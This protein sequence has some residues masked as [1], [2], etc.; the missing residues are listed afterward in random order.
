MF[1]QQQNAPQSYNIDTTV[2]RGGYSS[3]SYAGAQASASS[4]SS[5]F[6]GNFILFYLFS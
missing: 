3:G 5:N 4:Y 1:N 2:Q 6:E